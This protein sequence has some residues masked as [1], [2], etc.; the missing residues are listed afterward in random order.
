MKSTKSNLKS[1]IIYTGI[2][3]YSGIIITVVIG[4]ILA[5]LLTPAEFGI[6]ALVAV[7]TAFFS[8]LSNFGIGQA[9][10]QNQDLQERDLQSIFS[11]SILL[12]FT[13]S[14]LFFL[15]AP[16][17]ADFYN[18][19]VL[20]NVTRL[21]SLS[22]LFNTLQIVPKALYQKDMKFKKIG[23]I[24][25]AVN[26]TSGILAI[27]LAYLGFSY[28]ALVIQGI[29]S[30]LVT[31]I[32]FYLLKPIRISFKIELTSI[33]KI[34]KFTGYNFMFNFVNYFSR[35]ADNLLIGKFM[36]T[37]SLAFYNKAYTLMF[38]PVQNLTHVITPVLLPVL[39]KRQ[40]D[41]EYIYNSYL[42]VVKVLATIGFPLSVFLYFSSSEI[43]NIVYGSQWSQSIP[44]FKLLSLTVG[45]QMIYSSAGSIFMIINRTDV[46]FYFGIVGAFIVVGSIVYGIF[47]GNSL[48][49]VAFMLMGAFSLNFL[50]VFYLLIHVLLK[51]SF[52]NFLKITVSPILISLV[53]ASV[54]WFFSK[55]EIE[56]MFFKI[57]INIIISA[58]VFSV[59]FLAFKENR[60]LLKGGI[61]SYIGSN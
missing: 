35:N 54:L 44:I 9:V 34:I 18:E 14:A 33:S 1:G 55:I 12:G 11:F 24:S 17:I 52:L 30:G 47:I 5:R 15:S 57:L 28:Y 61:K 50:I 37:E 23:I 20:V 51:K 29:F 16:F 25:V 42:K 60:V 10:I 6:V 32:I 13:L 36:G 59:S 22:L 53:M 58:I 21:L 38:L 46:L 31:L 8:L 40:N 19:P 41:Y 7:F 39:S 49:S 27:V 45:I 4:A 2:S 3:R 43:I 56:N 48:E 26:L